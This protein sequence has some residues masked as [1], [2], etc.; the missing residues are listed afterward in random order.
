MCSRLIDHACLVQRQL[1][2]KG[3]QPEEGP[4]RPPVYRTLAA[5]IFSWRPGLTSVVSAVLFCV[6]PVTPTYPR[7][8]Q[9]VT[10]DLAVVVGRDGCLILGGRYSM[11]FF[12]MKLNDDGIVLWDWKVRRQRLE[13]ILLGGLAAVYAAP[14]RALLSWIEE[15]GIVPNDRDTRH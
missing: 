10:M 14:Y 7:E 13:R 4:H 1:K 12:V 9:A 15:R 2:H 8:D 6:S 3:R 11:D 5:R